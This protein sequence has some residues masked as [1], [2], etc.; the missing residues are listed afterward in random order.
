MFGIRTFRGLKILRGVLKF[1]FEVL[2]AMSNQQGAQFNAPDCEAPLVAMQS[3]INR[4]EITLTFSTAVPPP[5]PAQSSSS[6][7]DPT[8]YH[9]ALSSPQPGPSLQSRK[10]LSPIAESGPGVKHR[11]LIGVQYLE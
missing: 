3:K 1:T 9:S 11:T 8:Q 2:R 6:A 7:I 10:G 4:D 5:G